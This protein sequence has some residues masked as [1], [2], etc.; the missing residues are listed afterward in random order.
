MDSLHDLLWALRVQDLTPRLKLLGVKPEKVNKGCLI[1]TLKREYND[2]G[3]RRIWDS[4]SELDR[5][6]VAETVYHPDNL[7][8]ARKVRATYGGVPDF[9]IKPEGTKRWGYTQDSRN[10]ARIQLLLFPSIQTRQPGLPSDLV[11]SLRSFVPEPEAPRPPMLPGPPEE[12]GLILRETTPEAVAELRSLLRL[13][14]SGDLRASEKTSLPS[15]AGVHRMLGV[16]P[17]GDF[18]PPEIAFRPGRE[19][20]E[21]EIGALKPVGWTRMLHTARLVDIRG[22]KSKLTPKGMKALSAAP[23]ETLRMLWKKWV[24]NTR[25]DEFHR[26]EA[27][28]GQRGKTSRMTA[29]PPRRQAIESALRECPVGQWIDT[30]GFSRFMQAADL[31]FDVAR[32]LWRLYFCERQYGSLTYEGYG[33]WNILQHRYLL[34]LLFEYAATLGMVDVAYVHPAG[35]IPDLRGLWG[36]DDLE[37]LSRW[38]GLRAFRLTELG[39]YCL[40]L[41]ETYTPSLPPSTLRLE[42]GT[43]LV[44]RQTAGTLEPAD[45]LL[46]ESWAEPINEDSW[47][48]AP[49]LARRAVER[50]QNAEEFADFL[51]ERDPQPLP[52]TVEG[53]IDAAEQDGR[54]VRFQGEALLF[55]CRDAKTAQ[56]ICGHK[57]L[58]NICRPTGD[59]GIVVP[60][61]H[62]NTFRKTVRAMGL[63]VI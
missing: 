36:T 37:W 44:I 59:T 19:S 60:E 26:V 24:A 33:G 47:K 55:D 45:R 16:M 38:D 54:A 25:H 61:P 35:A 20:W 7:Y 6:A 39:A 49:L 56:R 51:R 29:K 34:G 58:Q 50:G 63:G 43:N 4:L 2:E 21:Q 42:T 48:L 22:T 8:N 53:F 5:A 13:A 18:Y 11:E 9:Y 41:S 32:D 52:Q 28:K 23:H 46:L 1:D 10:I 31:T 17:N 30:H 15:A 3:L 62:A 12:A 14:E 27:V 40:G 57:N